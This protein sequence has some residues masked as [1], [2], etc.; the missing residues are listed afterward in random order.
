M[1]CPRSYR[2]SEEPWGAS[3]SQEPIL[4]ETYAY[5]KLLQRTGRLV[6]V[7][8]AKIEPATIHIVH[9]E[10]KGPRRSVG[11]L[12]RKL[13]RRLEQNV[14]EVCRSLLSGKPALLL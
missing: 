12:T 14:H 4:D 13:F 5:I 2:R 6:E 10:N 7:S 8:E 11:S 1:P 9:S 3:L